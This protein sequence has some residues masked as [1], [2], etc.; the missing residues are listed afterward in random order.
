MTVAELKAELDAADDALE[1]HVGDS[2]GRGA[3]GHN[4]LATWSEANDVQEYVS[5]SAGHIVVIS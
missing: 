5:K 4:R 3:D 1:V 2:L